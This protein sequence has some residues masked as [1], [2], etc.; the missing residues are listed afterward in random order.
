[1]RSLYEALTKLEKTVALPLSLPSIGW[2][3]GGPSAKDNQRINPAGAICERVEQTPG[4]TAGLCGANWFW[5]WRSPPTPR[6]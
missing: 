1:M 3:W 2:C 6:L 4:A 5:T